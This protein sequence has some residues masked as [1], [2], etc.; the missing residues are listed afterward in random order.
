MRYP[1]G[2]EARGSS[3]GFPKETD[4]FQASIGRG[5]SLIKQEK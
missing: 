2:G 1:K 5:I 3:H 4:A